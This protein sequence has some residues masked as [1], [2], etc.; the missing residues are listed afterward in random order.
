MHVTE[1]SMREV[2]ASSS[3][4][5]KAH[6]TQAP[7][8]PPKGF[9]KK[10]TP[11]PLRYVAR[12]TTHKPKPLHSKPVKGNCHKCGRK[13]HYAKECRASAYVIELYRELQRLTNQ[14][15][16]NYNMDVQIDNNPDIENFM[17]LRGKFEDKANIALLG[18]A[19]TYTNLTNPKFFEF[20]GKETS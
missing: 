20:K 2:H 4:Q 19:S 18:S 16:Q 8:R 6:A 10:F 13:G 3:T 12:G 9:T 17:T 14:S 11:K 5:T 15:R 1:S 7:K